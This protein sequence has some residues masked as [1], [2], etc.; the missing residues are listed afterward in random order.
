M[1]ILGIGTEIVECPRIAQM[2]ERHGEVFLRR[3]YTER[4]IHYC[5]SRKTATQHYAARWAGKQAVIDALGLSSLSTTTDWRDIEIQPQVEG[6]TTVA[7]AG[8]VR[9]ACVKRGVLQ[10]EVSIAQCR[11]H[12][13]GYAIA[14]GDA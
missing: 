13:T 4:E 2:I 7:M 10:L 1:N 9:E 6:K 5:S 11:T 14:I 3:V 12:A 8:D